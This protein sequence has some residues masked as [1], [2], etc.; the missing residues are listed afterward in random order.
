MRSHEQRQLLGIGNAPAAGRRLKHNLL[1]LLDVEAEQGLRGVNPNA[2]PEGKAN[3]HA[4]VAQVG[5]F[6]SAISVWL[7]IVRVL[8]DAC[9]P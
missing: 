1:T 2:F 4:V 9:V 3:P 7:N 5:T 8:A 6:R